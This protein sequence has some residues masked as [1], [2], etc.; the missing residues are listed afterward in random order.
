MLF[1]SPALVPRPTVQPMYPAV[2]LVQARDGTDLPPSTD[3]TDAHA[4]ERG[5]QRLGNVPK[6]RGLALRHPGPLVCHC[7]S[8]MR[9][10]IPQTRQFGTGRVSDLG[11]HSRNSAHLDDVSA[12]LMAGRDD[13]GDRA[14]AGHGLR[15]GRPRLRGECGRDGR[16]GGAR[17]AAVEPSSDLGFGIAAGR[18]WRGPPAC[19]SV[20][21]AHAGAEPA[22]DYPC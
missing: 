22:Q 13:R 12:G 5:G 2:T 1:R 8:K 11:L 20:Q 4:A 15:L 18:G 7:A 10:S 16:G 21:Q 3:P 9:D 17:T 19:R 14:A 6:M